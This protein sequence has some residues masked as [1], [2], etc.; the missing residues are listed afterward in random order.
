MAQDLIGVPPDAEVWNI[1]SGNG[2]WHLW[3]VW[4][5][6]NTNPPVPIGWIFDSYEERKALGWTGKVD[7]TM[8]GDQFYKAGGIVMGRTTELADLSALSHPFDALLSMYESEVRVKPWLADP[9]VLATWAG[10]YLEGRSVT[11]A[12]LQGTE[13]WR[14]HSE[15]ERTWLSLNSSDPATAKRL[16]ADNRLRVA[17]MLREAGVSNAPSALVNDIADRWTSGQWTEAYAVNQ[18]RKIG[19]PSLP[20]ALDKTLNR[21]LMKGLDTTRAGEMDVQAL[22]N[23]WL[24]PAFSSG[25][26]AN[27]ISQWAAKLRNDPDGQTE[28]VETLRRQRQALYP[29]YDPNLTYDDIAAP[30]RGVWQDMWGEIPD[31]S[32]P[33]FQSIVKNNDL[34]TAQ[35]TLR[36]EGL[37]RGN[38]LVV[39]DALSA[40]SDSFG[41]G[42]RPANPAVL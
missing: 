34:S 42:V 19:D 31:E 22:V 41:S 13:W 2:Q 21:T 11:P 32:D 40:L 7:R 5:V 33:L 6:P 14:T 15:G 36:R 16:I 39:T 9:E 29:M 12:E 24:G 35:T 4:Y 18:I 30:W 10:A 20:I 25:W 1:R 28:L 26:N 27:M 8:T 3:L 37:R 38:G 23:Q 17:E